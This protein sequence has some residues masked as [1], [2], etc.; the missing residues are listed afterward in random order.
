MPTQLRSESTL[1]DITTLDLT[2]TTTFEGSLTGLGGLTVAGTITAFF[3]ERPAGSHLA[4]YQAVILEADLELTASGTLDF[5]GNLSGDAGT[6]NEHSNRQCDRPDLRGRR[7][8][9]RH[10]RPDNHWH[11]HLR[12]DPRRRRSIEPQRPRPPASKG[13]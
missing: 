1:D 9:P 5:N 13:T 12:V 4:S 2:A 3:S 7:S 8:R 10:T 11:N 6:D